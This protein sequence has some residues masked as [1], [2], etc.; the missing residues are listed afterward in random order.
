MES[1]TLNTDG[2][3]TPPRSRP[4][5]VKDQIRSFNQNLESR[6]RDKKFSLM[7]HSPDT[8]FQG[9]NH[10]F[11]TDFAESDWLGAFGGDKGTRI[12]I[13]GDLHFTNFGSFIDATGRLVYD[14]NNFDESIVADY[15]F[16][17]WRLGVSLVL[18]GRKNKKKSKGH[19]PNGGGMHPG[20]LAGS[21]KLPL[22]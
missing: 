12:W 11:W 10:L 8:F 21:Q 6:S 13:S 1:L 9:T 19:P 16:D 2:T 3:P 22:V 15:Q 20:L 14:L 17:L 4:S 7:A 18:L 5:W